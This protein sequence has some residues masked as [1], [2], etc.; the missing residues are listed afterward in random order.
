MSQSPSVDDKVL[1]VAA[2]PTHQA[3]L[4]A[5]QPLDEPP[6]V[7]VLGQGIRLGPVHPAVQHRREDTLQAVLGQVPGDLLPVVGAESGERADT[8]TTRRR[9]VDRHGHSVRPPDRPCR[10]A[11]SEH[12]L[13]N[14]RLQV[15]IP[16]QRENL[17]PV[18]VPHVG[19]DVAHRLFAHRQTEHPGRHYLTLPSRT[20]TWIAASTAGPG[21]SWVSSIPRWVP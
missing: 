1:L 16:A 12:D 19:H 20:F 18:P 4:F 13:G 11:R 17:P 15:V 14:Q 6:V 8:G 7:G 21:A 3:L 5:A 2:K 10:V 9:A